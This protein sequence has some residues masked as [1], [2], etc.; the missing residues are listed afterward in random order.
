MKIRTDFSVISIPFGLLVILMLY[1]LKVAS[2]DRLTIQGMVIDKVSNERLP[3]ASIALKNLPLSTVANLNGEFT[4][5]ISPKHREDTLMISMLGYKQKEIL[6]NVL[7]FR[8]KQRFSLSPSEKVLDGI[9]IKDSLTANEIIKLAIKRIPVNYPSYPVSMQAFYRE[10]QSVNGNYVSLVESAITMYNENR[11]KRNTFSGKTR[12]RVDELR[13]SFSHVHKYNDFWDTENLLLHALNLN[14]VPNN[15]KALEKGNYQREPNTTMDG[16]TVYVLRD[17]VMRIGI[18]RFFVESHSYAV[19]RI[20]NSYNA[21]NMPKVTW[22]YDD[23]DSMVIHPKHRNLVISFRKYNERYHLNYLSMD[24]AHHYVING[25]NRDVFGIKQDIIINQINTKNPVK[26]DRKVKARLN[27]TLESHQ[28]DFNREF[29]SSYNMLKETPL[30]KKL[31]EDLEK[32]VSL[33]DQFEQ[34]STKEKQ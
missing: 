11:F 10:S 32:E 18:M 34:Q 19:I 13:R 1:S 17:T 7:T 33:Q 14:P 5:H 2:Q 23:Y 31:V 3:F 15:S 4:F 9:V 8:Q 16:K 30:E 24:H 26:I 6:L 20:T 28:Y 29:W 22:E 25:E 27:K 12:V 21:D